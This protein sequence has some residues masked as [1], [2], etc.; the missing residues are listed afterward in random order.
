M[1]SLG[2][3]GY[4][5]F[6]VAVDEEARREARR[7]TWRAATAKRYRRYCELCILH[8]ET[9]REPWPQH[10]VELSGREPPAPAI[11]P[12]RNID[13]L[14]RETCEFR[15]YWLER[16]TL[17]EIREMGGTIDYLDADLSRFARGRRPRGRTDVAA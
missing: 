8:G 10:M 11:L 12:A 17:E 9:R 6:P 16:F 3:N 7:R 15:R 13:L 2:R 14:L 4:G 1:S 5:S